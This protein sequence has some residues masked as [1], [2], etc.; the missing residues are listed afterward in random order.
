M[1]VIFACLHSSWMLLTCSSGG[2]PRRRKR[3][4]ISGPAQLA[5]MPDSDQARLRAMRRRRQDGLESSDEGGRLSDSSTTVPDMD[6][7]VRQESICGSSPLSSITANDMGS[8]GD[9]EDKLSVRPSLGDPD[10]AGAPSVSASR[11]KVPPHPHSHTHSLP[12]TTHTL[13]T[14]QPQQPQSYNSPQSP[15]TQLPPKSPVH[16][17]DEIAY[18]FLSC[19]KGV[20]KGDAPSDMATEPSPSG[21]Q[22][23][24]SVR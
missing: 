12:V 6:P 8:A 5:V 16:E 4:G 9:T 15:Y 23:L 17:R 20:V 10:S 1:L 3:P 19:D 13:N 11:F 21:E 14:V 22:R 18:R 2:P 24:V 7:S